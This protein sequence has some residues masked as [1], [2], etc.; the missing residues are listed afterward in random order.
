[1][2]NKKIM[3]IIIII[4]II[5][6]FCVIYT[7]RS[8]RKP[9]GKHVLIIQDNQIIYNL[10]LETA[11]D[12]EIRINYQNHYNMIKI[13]NHEICISEADCPDQTCIRTGVLKSETL[14]IVCLPHKLIIRYAEEGES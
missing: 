7:V 8:F 14:P 11:E 3:I 6:I 1:V 13:Q 12:Q 9:S 2:K 5:L 10:D 4:I